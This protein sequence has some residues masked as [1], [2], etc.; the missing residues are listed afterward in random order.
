[1]DVFL[2]ELAEI[3]RKF[4]KNI[5]NDFFTIFN[6]Q[7]FAYLNCVDKNININYNVCISNIDKKDK[8][9][10]DRMNVKRIFSSVMALGLAVTLTACGGNKSGTD[11]D[12]AS[13]TAS[14]ETSA[15]SGEETA[16][17]F[18]TQTSDDTLV[19]GVDSIGGDFIQGFANSAHDVAVRKL[20]GIEGS[21]GYNTYIQDES[22]EWVYNSAAL[23][24]EP[25][26]TDNEDGSKTVN[27]KLKSDLKWSD[28]EPITSDDY[29]FAS[30]M[31]S[32]SDYNTLT[33][34][35]EIGS[36]SLKGYAAYRD[37]ESDEFEGLNKISDTEF[38][39]TIDKDFLP[40]Y[41]EA[42]LKAMT[43]RPMHLEAG[44]LTVDKNKV[45]VKSD[46]EV[47]EDD[48]KAYIES[49]ESQIANENSS[50]DEEKEA[51]E[52]GK[53]DDDTQAAH[54]DAIKALEEKK[55]LAE[56]GEG[57][58]NTQL[59]FEQAMIY[60]TE[61][62]RKSPTV[63]CGPYKFK[64]FANNMAKL[65]LNENYTQDFKGKKAT[66]PHVIV[67][68]VNS[69]IAVD[70]LE[71]GDIDVWEEEADG[72]HIDQM[73]KASDDGKIGGYKT[74]DRNGY[75]NLIFLTDRSATQYKEVRQ[76]VAFLM[77]R[78]DFV[79]NFAG[80]YAVVTNGM[81]GSSQW[82]YKERGAD[83]ESKLTNYT[84]NVDE[85]NT[86]LD[87]SPYKF[88]SDGKTAWDA[89]KAQEAYQS[90]SE[91]F[92]Y[93]RYNEKGEKLQINQY[94]SQDSEIT[95]LLNNQLPDNAK[96]AGMEYNVQAGDFNTL[97]NYLYF[98]TEDAEYTAFNMGTNFGTPFDPYYQYSSEGNDNRSKTNDPAVDEITKKLR[99]TDP[100]DKEGYL[101]EWEEFELWYND[102]LP[103]IPLYSNQ[104][105]SGYTKRVKG[106]DTITPVWGV[107]CEINNMS[108]E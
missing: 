102:Y 3:I 103:E 13:T 25:K 6:Y 97:L 74:F 22:G 29:L 30:L 17:N 78:N 50:F 69:K 87:Q 45:A 2:H 38:E 35:T 31:L 55:S 67:Q 80:G 32:N 77:D 37:G 57:I 1:M 34:S 94:G 89:T 66:I 4:P 73:R 106:Y 70:L 98:P 16:E 88:E 100:S 96:Q 11:G 93:Y 79:Q 54:D 61:T 43:L 7:S 91:G 27:Y 75:G 84:L 26:T 71:N 14:T 46:Y 19:V 60:D 68:A 39:I 99:Q 82:M 23:E 10:R 42:A 5:Q 53:V 90:N 105:H 33:G 81:Y 83:L 40:Y 62:Y 95:T 20:M 58:D 48:K 15:E 47:T 86:R 85:A 104:Y 21:V 24:E 44:H 76:A 59:L 107:E 63:T 12:K 64:E 52:D 9:R 108:L 56:S 28:G 51:A 49:I 36:D 18:K 8:K 65:D 92:D 101:D 41:E 72:S